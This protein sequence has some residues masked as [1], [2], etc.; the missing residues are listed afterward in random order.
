M[1]TKTLDFTTLAVAD[2]A[3]PP[4]GYTQPAGSN[5]AKIFN[6]GTKEWTSTGTQ[7]IWYD[8]TTLTGT[9]ISCTVKLGTVGGNSCGA[10]IIDANGDGWMIT[11]NNTN[12]INLR[13]VVNSQ[14]VLTVLRSFSQVIAT[15]G[16][17][18]LERNTLTGEL[19]TYYGGVNLDP[20][21]IGYAGGTTPNARFAGA[22]SRFGYVRELTSDYTPAQTVTSINGGSPITSSQSAVAAIT[23]GFTGLP[24]TITTDATGVTCGTITGTTNAP[25]WVQPI[26]TDGAIFPKSGTVV[27]YTFTNGSETANGDQTINKD[28][29]QTT[30]I[31]A[32]PINDDITCLFGAIFAA[33]GRSA[34]NNDEIYH[35]V[36]AGMSDLVVNPD[37]T[38]EVTNAGTFDCWVWTNA[39]GINYYY[40][41]TIT[42][43]GGVVI[44][45]GLT[46]IGL[47]SSGLT[48]VGLTS[49]G[50]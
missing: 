8:N 9:I 32:L 41:V 30:V 22:V 39:T 50:L 21:G 10:A 33:T 46:S 12:T 29:D 14:I 27:T 48:R 20:S 45:G 47:T 3:S 4:T 36:P 35:T 34:A 25:A 28:A 18:K 26:R 31:V 13:A 19:K 37:G 16:L 2:P 24:T 17:L 1:A 42:E 23:T 43:S 40:S 15:N 5:N 7:A 6:T 49:S 44:N 38:M 11:T